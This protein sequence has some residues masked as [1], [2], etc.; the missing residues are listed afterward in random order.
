MW[1]KDSKTLYCLVPSSLA[2][3]EQYPDIWY[4]G[5]E[6]YNDS[7]YKIDGR[8]GKAELLSDFPV[9]YSEN[10]DVF[11]VGIDENTDYLYFI[12]KKTEYLWSYRLL[13]V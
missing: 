9:D 11:K 8:S 1:T 12:D 2:Y 5:M 10:L 6:T 3:K 13:D 4:Q 7:L